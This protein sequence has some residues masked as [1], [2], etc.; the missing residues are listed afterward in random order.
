MSFAIELNQ[1][2]SNRTL[3][4]ARRRQTEIMLETR[5][6]TEDQPI[7]GELQYTET[8]ELSL[9]VRSNPGIVPESLIGV[10]VEGHFQLGEFRYLFST[11]IVDTRTEDGWGHLILARPEAVMA[12]QRRRFWRTRF[13][14]SS[15]VKVVH[16]PD[17]R[18][19][20]MFGDLCNISPDGLAMRV[21]ADEA[22]ALL[23]GD[24]IQTYFELPGLDHSFSFDAVICNKTPG[25][26][27]D[28]LVLGLQFTSLD[29]AEHDL[30]ALRNHLRGET[31]YITEQEAGE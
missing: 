6:G 18:D 4:Q 17:G 24:T 7:V 13:A 29:C 16:H 2:Q 8:D 12:L 10:Y 5:A 15:D 1:R 3:E 27:K 21:L 11:H 25:G 19:E 20:M 22:D 31:E 9:K 23:I 28:V 30:M 26:S 14:N